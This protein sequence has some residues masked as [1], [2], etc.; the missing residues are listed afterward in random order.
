MKIRLALCNL[1]LLAGLCLAVE[2]RA[3]AYADAGT[4]LLVLQSIGAM[5]SGVMFF[6]RKQIKAGLF[7][8][9]LERQ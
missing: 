4:G 9:K 5:V 2:H 7:K 1:L 8:K 6:L 3:Y